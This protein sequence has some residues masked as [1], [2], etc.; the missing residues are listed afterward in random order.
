MTS[1]IP[2]SEFFAL[3]WRG[4]RFSYLWKQHRSRWFPVDQPPRVSDA[5]DL[6]FGVNPVA[7]RRGP[8]ERATNA[9]VASV[10][11]CCGDVDGKDF[12]PVLSNEVE[13][14]LPVILQ[15]EP[16]L[17]KD[18]ARRRAIVEIRRR[19]FHADSSMYMALARQHIQGLPCQPSV[20]VCSG[21]GYYPFWLLDRPFLI[22]N[23]NE[24]ERARRLQARW[25]DHIGAD[26]AAKDLARMLRVP[27]TWNT[28]YNPPRPVQFV[29]INLDCVYSIAQLEA[30]LPRPE[31]RVADSYALC[32]QSLGSATISF[33]AALSRLADACEY[34]RNDTLNRTAFLAGQLVAAEKL[35][36]PDAER[37]LLTVALQIG[38]GDRESIRTIR[39]G[40][41]AGLRRQHSSKILHHVETRCDGLRVRPVTGSHPKLRTVTIERP[42]YDTAQ[43]S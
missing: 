37:Q 7:E 29:S 11:C 27:G 33:Q 31:P 35:Y 16:S 18:Q 13:P 39:S 6:Y 3:L 10:S 20:V 42:D 28:K 38:L 14:L 9:S 12:V 36:R 30:L 15:A 25:V 21:G 34:T 8:W 26:P 41:D 32:S 1:P 4:G 24:R 43:C 22:T 2:L 5:T 19:K 23:D 40:L 17:S